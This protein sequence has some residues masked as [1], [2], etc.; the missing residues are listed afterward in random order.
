MDISIKPEEV[1][2]NEDLSWLGTRDGRNNMRSITL[3]SD[4]FDDAH[5]AEKG[6][7]PSGTAL[8]E[9]APGLYG[10]YGAGLVDTDETQVITRTSTAGTFTITVTDGDGVE[11]TTGPITAV[12]GV[13]AANINTALANA[14][15][16][17]I[18]A[19]GS[20]GGPFTLTYSGGDWADSDVDLAVIDDDLATGGTVTIAPGVPGEGGAGFAGFLGT[21]TKIDKENGSKVG[22]ALMW[23][24]VIKRDRLPTFDATTVGELDATAIASAAGGK[25]RFENSM[26]KVVTT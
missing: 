13:T 10:P 18:V 23:T 7:V 4:L 14:G 16:V 11:T 12:A 24:G 9:Y 22:A 3:D 6:A 26:N 1:F 8:A 17:G 20:A 19:T 15:I 21:T 5:I 2:Q 25:F